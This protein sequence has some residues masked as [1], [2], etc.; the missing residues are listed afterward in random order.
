M[1]IEK[2]W[3]GKLVIGAGEGCSS[4]GL[5][6]ACS[7]AGAA[8]LLLESS[9]AEAKAVLRDGGIDFLVSTVDEGLRTLKNEIRKERPLA[10]VVSGD[11]SAALAEL[12]ERGVLPD[13][14]LQAPTSAFPTG[15]TA[16]ADV[17]RLEM[18]AE[19]ST[20]E[21]RGFLSDR[22]L[23]SCTWPL[24]GRAAV[25]AFDQELL[26]LIDEE[27]ALRRRWLEGIGRHQRSADQDYRTCWVTEAE[28]DQIADLLTGQA[29]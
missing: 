7:L 14:F 9:A 18:S 15:T 8:C 26:E 29:L 17:R 20:E 24:P 2:S 10:V 28:L 12:L 25:R 1:A 3:A 16:W 6:A 13:L 21:L 22:E 19:D 4:S 23:V 11:A 5:P 27:D